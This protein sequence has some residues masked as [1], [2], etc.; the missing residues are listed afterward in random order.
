MLEAWSEVDKD[1]AELNGNVSSFRLSEA[2]A[3]LEAMNQEKASTLFYGNSSLNPEEFNGL[4]TRYSSISTG[5]ISTNVLDGGGSGSDNTSVW[6]IV[7]GPQTLS[8][9]FPKGSPAGL[10]HENLGLQTIE[11][12]AGVAGTRM[13]AYQDH[14]Q[15]KCGIAVKD[16]RYAVRIANIDI[17]DLVAH[18][19]PADLT[20]LMI[21]AIHRIPNL[22]MGRAAFY[23]NRTVMQMLDIQRRD[24]VITG[25]GLSFEVV[26][27]RRI[28]TFRGIPLRLVDALVETE[29]TL[30]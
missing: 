17:S 26:D 6:L 5:D 1:L 13:R 16:W 24:D 3:F 15:W 7:W 8:G 27:G 12:T 21:R 9:I 19:T 28:P 29:A 2:A 14:W 30:T 23:M 10:T 25:G 18:A 20:D 4:A 11:V 22:S